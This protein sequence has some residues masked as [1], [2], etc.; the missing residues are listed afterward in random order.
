[1][2]YNEKRKEGHSSSQTTTFSFSFATLVR[3]KVALLHPNRT[4]IKE[5]V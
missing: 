2:L 4:L 3:V 5:I 1:M